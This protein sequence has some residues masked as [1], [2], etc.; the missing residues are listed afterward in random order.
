M[1]KFNSWFMSKLINLMIILIVAS[2]C[3]SDDPLE[4]T[5]P[6]DLR[7]A[8]RW[9]IE[10]FEDSTGLYDYNNYFRF[11]EFFFQ[12]DTAIM[13]INQVSP[14][15]VEPKISS[16]IYVLD[17]NDEKSTIYLGEWASAPFEYII[18]YDSIGV[19]FEGDNKVFLNTSSIRNYILIRRENSPN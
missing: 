19:Q 3:Q 7:L 15:V 9:E 11:T 1:I 5:M 17:Y 13:I 12:P 10:S 6:L 2:S 14:I 16:K 18:A 8:G 4:P